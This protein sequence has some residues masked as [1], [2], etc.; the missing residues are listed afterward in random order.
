MRTN[1]KRYRIVVLTDLHKSSG[2]ILK[3]SVGLAKMINGEIEV[4]HVK[5]PSEIVD[6][7]NQLSA[8]RVLN[9][10][11]VSI[12]KKIQNTITPISREFGMK[13]PYSFAF[14]NVKNEISAFIKKRQPDIIVLG[15]RR[16]NPFNLIGD[17]ITEFVLNTYNGVV[18]IAADKDAILPGK[19][20]SLGT[21]N[22]SKAFLNLDFADDLMKYMQKPLKSFKVIKNTAAVKEVSK[23]VDEGTIEYVFENNDGTIKNLSKYMSKNNINLLSIDRG[24][25]DRAIEQKLL[26]PDINSVVGKLNVNLLISAK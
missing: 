7:E 24:Q 23:A 10:K 26:I 14:G 20:I 11:H 18:L 5:K 16:S 22:S 17:S 8:M 25:K 1:K 2:T 4:F 21:L 9:S 13:I 6:S 12:D 3:S 19:E 15:K